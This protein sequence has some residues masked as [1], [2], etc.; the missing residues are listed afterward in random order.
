[1]PN[2]QAKG[3]SGPDRA[4]QRLPGAAYR[5]RPGKEIL[6]GRTSNQSTSQE[7]D[8]STAKEW[9]AVNEIVP[10]DKLLPRA[11]E[12]AEGLA[13]LPPLVERAGLNGK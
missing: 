6:T 12:I 4:G 10:A 1:M 9:G 3:A 7:L 13:K 8:A 2:Q 5:I 11:R